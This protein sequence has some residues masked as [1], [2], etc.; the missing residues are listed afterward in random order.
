MKR[1]KKWEKMKRKTWHGEESARCFAARHE[2]G[3]VEKK[4]L[5]KCN[6]QSTSNKQQNYVYIC[7]QSDKGWR[8]LIRRVCW[9]EPHLCNLHAPCIP[10]PSFFL[11]CFIFVL[12]YSSNPSKLG[13]PLLFLLASYAFTSL[14]YP[15]AHTLL[16]PAI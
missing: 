15:A 5:G 2:V 11:F 10:V 8:K 6:T 9:F 3:H 13:R 14:Y 12:T 16:L 4:G 1:R 7:K